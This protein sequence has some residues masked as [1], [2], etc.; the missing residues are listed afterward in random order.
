MIVIILS[1]MFSD[2]NDKKTGLEQNECP[3]VFVFGGSILLV[4]QTFVQVFQEE[5][6]GRSD[7]WS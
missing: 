6:S 1:C 5:I 2:E 3:V 4:S 7:S